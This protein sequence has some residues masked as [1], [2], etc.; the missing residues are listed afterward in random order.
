V[1]GSGPG[2][3]FARL[4]PRQASM[5]RQFLAALPVPVAASVASGNAARLYR[6]PR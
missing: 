5:T 2:L 1:R 3:Q 4:V 6:L